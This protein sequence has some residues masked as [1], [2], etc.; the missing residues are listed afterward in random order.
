MMKS[1]EGVAARKTLGLTQE[2]L[3]AELGL[4]PSVI[5]AWEVGTVRIPRRFED[6]LRLTLP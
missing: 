4:T 2:A 3:A 5:A 1:D 6:Q